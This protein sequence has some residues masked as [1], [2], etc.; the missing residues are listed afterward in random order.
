MSSVRATGQLFCRYDRAI[1]QLYP[2]DISSS[3]SY[4]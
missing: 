4:V 1:K 3:S 2:I